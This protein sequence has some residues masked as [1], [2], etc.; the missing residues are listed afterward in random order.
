MTI[1]KVV[2]KKIINLGNLYSA[3]AVDP[4]TRVFEVDHRMCMS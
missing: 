1:Y 4:R 2:Q 3:H